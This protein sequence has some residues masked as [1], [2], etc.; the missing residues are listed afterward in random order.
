MAHSQHMPTIWQLRLSKEYESCSKK[1]QADSPVNR[2]PQIEK[3]NGHQREHVSQPKVS[4]SRHTYSR[5]SEQAAKNYTPTA[6]R[7]KR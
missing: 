4:N 6:Y 7:N 1:N 3:L 2:K 5:P